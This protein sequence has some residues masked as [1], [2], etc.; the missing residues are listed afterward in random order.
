MPDPAEHRASAP[1]TV[2]DCGFPMDMCTCPSPLC[3][4][5]RAQ[6]DRVFGQLSSAVLKRPEQNSLARHPKSSAQQVVLFSVALGDVVEEVDSHARLRNG[7]DAPSD[8]SNE[9]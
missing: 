9:Q 2:L 6:P 7:R 1:P 8:Y 5:G 4:G 3:S